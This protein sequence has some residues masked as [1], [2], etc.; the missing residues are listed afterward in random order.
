MALEYH[1]EYGRLVP[2]VEPVI[3]FYLLLE[4]G[5]PENSFYISQFS[6]VH[7]VLYHGSQESDIILHH[8]DENLE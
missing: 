8:Q 1:V 6:R 4:P 5:V 7:K 3:K 2:K